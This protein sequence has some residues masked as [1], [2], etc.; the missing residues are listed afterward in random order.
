[1]N[2]RIMLVD[3]QIIFEEELA[4]AVRLP[5]FDVIELEFDDEADD[6]DYYLADIEGDGNVY[7]FYSD[8]EEVA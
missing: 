7:S 5:V 6:L 4:C 8:D 1:M 3:G 2:N